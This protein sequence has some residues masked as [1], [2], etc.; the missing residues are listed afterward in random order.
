VLAGEYDGGPT[1]ALASRLAALFPHGETA[2]LP[3]AGHFPWVDAPGD[4]ART[5]AAFLEPGVQSVRTASGIR[6]AYRAWGEAGAPPVVL[7]HG[8]GGSGADWTQV[9]EGLAATHRVHALDLRGH[10]LSDW[11]GSYSFEG[12]RDDLRGFIDALG[13][14]GADVVAHSM[15]G[16]AALLLAQEAPGLVGRL[17]LEEAPPLLP[18]DPPR[19]FVARPDEEL[20]F[21]WP[22]VPD[23]NVQLNAPD[24]AWRKGMAELAVPVLLVAGG[25]SSH[26]DQDRIAEMADLIPDAR[27][28]TFDI[29]HSVHAVLPD[30]FL[31]ALREFGI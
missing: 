20:S 21:D 13:L 6:L 17:V 26:I 11:P 24:P 9:A 5:V 25:G 12:F 22:V 31:A 28:V 8:R 18:L 14:A 23:V 27:L 29:G 3:G 7:V 1:P 16:A 2:V 4:F 15:G 19:G 10:G 30:E